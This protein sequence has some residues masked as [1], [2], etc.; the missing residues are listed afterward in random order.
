MATKKGWLGTDELTWLWEQGKHI[1][2]VLQ[3]KGAA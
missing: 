2:K 1:D 3:N